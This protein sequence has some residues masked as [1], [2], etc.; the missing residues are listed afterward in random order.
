VPARDSTLE[1]LTK[2]LYEVVR[3]AASEPEDLE[4]Q[5]PVLS[6]FFRVAAVPFKTDAEQVHYIT[7]RLIPDYVERLPQ[8]PEANAI[9][10]L[11]LYED[12]G[13]PRSL[14][15]R[16]AKAE[17]CLGI[18]TSN[19][20][21]RHEPRLLRSCAR[22]FLILDR[23][24]SLDAMLHQVEKDAG[25]SLGLSEP[26]N[27]SPVATTLWNQ[28]LEEQLDRLTAIQEGVVPVR[29]QDE[30][31][32]LFV[33]LT[34]DAESSLHAVDQTSLERWFTDRRL[35][36]YLDA[37]LQRAQSGEV[38]VTRLRVVR[39]DD[40][41]EARQ[42][43]LLREFITLHEN[44]G[45]Q[46]VLSHEDELRGLNTSFLRGRHP[47]DRLILAIIDYSTRP[48]CLS[49]ELDEEG[50]VKQSILYLRSLAQVRRYYADLQTVLEDITYREKHGRGVAALLAQHHDPPLADTPP[51]DAPH[52]RWPLAAPVM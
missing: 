15:S 48:A 7:R 45:A 4:G 30:M 3:K 18:R 38:R 11:F 41:S 52:P 21:R 32:D 23:D 5:V 26:E 29:D 34:H 49:G 40:L 9:A 6:G 22:Q 31:L 10:E 51:T 42:R 27:L 12:R 37:Q 17:A 8:G 39:Q 35:R 36:R 44:A 25:S 13:V 20:A 43:N 50:Y 1:R 19:F 14:T 2:E 24:D 46:L 16:Y 28:T 33:K 47:E